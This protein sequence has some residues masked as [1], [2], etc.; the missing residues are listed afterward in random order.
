MLL[1]EMTW[2]AVKARAPD[3]PVIIPV[4]ALE[5]HGHH[6]PLFT[7]SLLLGEVVRRAHEPLAER[8][9]FAPLQ[10]LGNSDHHLDYAG[11]LSAPPRLYLDLLNGLLENLIHHGFRRLLIVNGHGGNTIPGQQAVFE[12]RQRHRGRSDLLLLFATYWSLGGKPAEVNPNLQQQSMGHACEWETSMMLRIRPDLVGPLD[13]LEAVSRDFSFEPAYH[14][15]VTQDRSV[16]G[17]MGDPRHATAEKGETLF[18]VFAADLVK[19]VER[20]L[21]WDGRSWRE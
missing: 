19:M 11:T 10:W 13:R 16:P 4:A 8:A 20:M 9:I 5:Q 1:A 21:A 17:H 18:Q 3:T 14:G 15:W 7:D 2:P 6:M 12:T